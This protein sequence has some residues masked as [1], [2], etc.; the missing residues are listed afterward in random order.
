MTSLNVSIRRSLVLRVCSCFLLNL[1]HL[2]FAIV[3]RDPQEEESCV[4]I[5][6]NCLTQ[7]ELEAGG[8]FWVDRD[9]GFVLATLH[10]CI[11]QVLKH[12]K[13]ARETLAMV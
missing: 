7:A 8:F 12:L 4:K 13:D 1:S 3:N 11:Q 5:R 2:L 9:R 6:W 10:E